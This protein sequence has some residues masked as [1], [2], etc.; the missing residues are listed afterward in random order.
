[1]VRA[2]TRAPLSPG[3]V[4]GFLAAPWGESFASLFGPLTASWQRRWAT[5]LQPR[6]CGSLGSP[7]G[8]CQAG[9]DEEAV[10]SIVI[11]VS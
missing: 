3:E 5:S 2:E 9:Q 10:F 7:R 8:L 6:E 11:L 1:M 4:S